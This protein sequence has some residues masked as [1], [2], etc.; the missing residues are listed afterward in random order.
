MYR[1]NSDIAIDFT[2]NHIE[3]MLSNMYILEFEV[4]KPRYTNSN[5]NQHQ[6]NLS[7]SIDFVFCEWCTVYIVRILALEFKNVNIFRVVFHISYHIRTSDSAGLSA[8]VILDNSS[9]N[10]L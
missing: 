4:K 5:V 8:F 3:V 9:R 2:F 1:N 7:E 6:N 10:C